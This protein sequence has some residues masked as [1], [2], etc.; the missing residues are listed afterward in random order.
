[1]D[2]KNNS[3]SNIIISE[4]VIAKIASVAAMDTPGVAAVVPKTA[5]IKNL[6]KRDNSSKSITFNQSGNQSVIDIYISTKAGY[7]I[8]DIC[9]KLQQNIKESVQNMTNLV[10]SKVNVHIV[11]IDLKEQA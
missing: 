2:I 5:D 9:E 11:S 3:T 4:E 10:V 7:K 1:M 6:I 8:V